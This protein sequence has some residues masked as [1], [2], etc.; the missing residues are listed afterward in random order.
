[1]KNTTE[2][3]SFFTFNGYKYLIVGFTGYYRTA[4]PDSSEYIDASALGEC[5]YD[6]L[7]V[8][9]VAS[10][11]ERRI[12]AGW[13]PGAMGWGGAMMHREL[14]PEKDGVLGMRWVPEMVPETLRDPIFEDWNGSAPLALPEK[15]SLMLT[16]SVTPDENGFFSLVFADG[17]KKTVLW[18]DTKSERAGFAD[19]ENANILTAAEQL[20]AVGDNVD[21]YPQANLS[22]IP[23]N[24]YNYTLSNM[25]GTDRSFPL[26]LICRYS[27]R[28]RATV[29]DVEIAERRTMISVRS[30]FYPTALSLGEKNGARIFGGS[31]FRISVAE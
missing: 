4:S 19:T 26:R 30:D 20:R 1:M 18:I 31:L 2:C 12:M 10:L 7:G 23:R 9:M 16:L 14:L 6:G 13:V 3:P 25:K 21:I 17:E 29:L 27:R 11:G 28:M 22:D 15:T 5:I 24:A 8:P